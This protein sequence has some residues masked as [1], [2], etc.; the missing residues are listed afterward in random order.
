MLKIVEDRR[1]V[2]TY[3]YP[4]RAMPFGPV[5]CI[6]LDIVEIGVSVPSARHRPYLMTLKVVP[7]D[8]HYLEACVFGCGAADFPEQ[9]LSGLDA[10]NSLIYAT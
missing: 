10:N 5:V 2:F 6:H 4:D 1:S 9:F 3:T 8:P 7:A